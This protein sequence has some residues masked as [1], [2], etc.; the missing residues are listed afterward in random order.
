MDVRDLKY[1]M[2]TISTGGDEVFFGKQFRNG[3][4]D[5]HLMDCSVEDY[6][7]GIF[8]SC[9]YILRNSRLFFA[10]TLKT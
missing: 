8:S 9:E 1:L 4:G 3:M 7:C 2:P 5:F 6:I 10:F